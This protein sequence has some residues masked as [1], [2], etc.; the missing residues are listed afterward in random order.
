MATEREAW[1]EGPSVGDSGTR[2]KFS[3]FRS[4][5]W[6]VKSTTSIDHFLRL[7]SFSPFLPPSIISGTYFI[8]QPVAV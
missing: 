6:V 1:G 5:S 2:S 4:A 7:S 8:V 3:S